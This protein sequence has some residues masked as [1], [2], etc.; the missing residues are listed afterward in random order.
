MCI[1]SDVVCG[2]EHGLILVGQTKIKLMTLTNN[3]IVASP[4]LSPE[5]SPQ[6]EILILSP[7]IQ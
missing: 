3:E 4:G 1:S 2:G 6:C 7:L 5:V